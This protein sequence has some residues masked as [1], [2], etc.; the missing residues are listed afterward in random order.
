MSSMSIRLPNRSSLTEGDMI[1]LGKTVPA[2]LKVRV[3]NT[4]FGSAV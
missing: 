4:L 1:V 2:Y 3:M